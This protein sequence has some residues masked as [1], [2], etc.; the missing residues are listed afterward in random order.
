VIG[1]GPPWPNGPEYHLTYRIRR[2]PDVERPL[3][4]APPR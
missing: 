2:L 3:V 4:I 1:C